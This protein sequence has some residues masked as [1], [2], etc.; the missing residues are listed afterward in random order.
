MPAS[1]P[2]HPA[3]R[4]AIAVTTSL[5][6]SRQFVDRT[7]F[8]NPAI[9]E[10]VSTI[11]AAAYSDRDRRVVEALRNSLEFIDMTPHAAA[12]LIRAA[13]AEMEQGL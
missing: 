11:I 3:R 1:K 9:T 10:K 12:E 8:S 4:A 7:G 2:E 6:D 5:N 13:L